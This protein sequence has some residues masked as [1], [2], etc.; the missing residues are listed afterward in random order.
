M[1][2]FFQSGWLRRCAKALRGMHGL[3][4]WHSS[5]FKHARLMRWTQAMA[6]K[7]AHAAVD[8]WA[9]ERHRFVETAAETLQAKDLG[10][11]SWL[12]LGLRETTQGACRDVLKWLLALPGLRV[13]GDQRRTGE[14]LIS[15]Q[16][17]LAHSLF[18]DIPLE[19][20]Y[21]YDATC[22][23]GR[24]PLSDQEWWKQRAKPLLLSV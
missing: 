8:S 13:P 15:G 6:V 23:K 7:K 9:E 5:M 20:N 11:I 22:C 10:D 17:R 4:N 2:C 21:Y 24:Y 18:G 12:E 14:R 3:W 1:A 19:R 16:K